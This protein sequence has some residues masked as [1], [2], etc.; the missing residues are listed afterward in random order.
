MAGIP[1]VMAVPSGDENGVVTF[2]FFCPS[3]NVDL[4]LS[5]D[6]KKNLVTVWMD[7]LAQPRSRPNAHCRQFAEFGA[8]EDLTEVDILLGQ[9]YD[10][11]IE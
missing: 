10:V 6:N 11:F 8:I 4:T 2:R 3:I 7:F 1:E 9:F 5:L